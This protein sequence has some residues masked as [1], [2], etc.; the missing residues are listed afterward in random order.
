METITKDTVLAA[1]N[2]SPKRRCFAIHP[3]IQHGSKSFAVN[4][5]ETIKK[6]FEADTGLELSKDPNPDRFFRE[7]ETDDELNKI[8]EWQKK[9]GDLVYLRDCLSLS[10]AIEIN[11]TDDPN[12]QAEPVSGIVS[13]TKMGKLVHDGKWS[14]DENAI[15]EIANKVK[16][17]I[18]CLP[19]YK[20]ADM[21]CSVP[22]SRDK[23]FDLPSKVT[24]LVSGRINK[25]DVTNGFDFGGEKL[26]V[27]G[28][29]VDEKWEVWED[30][31]SSFQRFDVEG[32]SIIL[33]DDL[34]QSG[35][36]IQYIAMKLQ[37]AGAREVY[38]LCFVKTWRNTGNV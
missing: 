15:N 2:K 29:S 32:K 30:A 37:Q 20:D 10:I 1:H 23:D 33:I 3:G 4:F 27:R 35:R 9:Q 11:K 7:I 34:Y 5:P 16:E 8:E 25:L 13:Y 28:S 38:G 19:Y 26:S 31:E 36:T 24:S 18:Q 17:V 21:I 22:P 12:K 6:I 14:K